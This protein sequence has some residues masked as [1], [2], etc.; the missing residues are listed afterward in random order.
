[1]TGAVRP[2]DDLQPAVGV[3]DQGREALDAVAVAAVLLMP[4]P[5]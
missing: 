4:T 2:V 1:M 5:L 3:L